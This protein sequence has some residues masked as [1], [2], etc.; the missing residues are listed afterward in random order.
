MKKTALLL[1]A[2]FAIACA[3]TAKT[4]KAPLYEVLTSQQYGGANIR[5]YEILTEAK[6]IAM[7]Q[8]DPNLKNKIKE[9]DINTS[10]FLIL[11][12]GE[13]TSGGYGIEVV[14]V[15]ETP[16]KIIVTV[17][18]NHPAEGAVA[19]MALSNPYTIVK[20]NSKKPIEIK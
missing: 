9:N 19:T 3:P 15:E 5:F 7:L 4:G 13:K 10:N 20:I 12:A 17:R 8:S 14:N 18:E 1:I 6:E 11:N 16:D 2:L